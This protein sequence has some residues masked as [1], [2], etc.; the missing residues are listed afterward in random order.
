MKRKKKPTKKFIVFAAILLI[1]VLI[2]MGNKENDE[3]EKTDISN[4]Q[5][6][7]PE[8]PK[9]PEELEKLEEAENPEESIVELEIEEPYEENPGSLAGV[10][11]PDNIIIEKPEVIGVLVNKT[12]TLPASYAPEDLVTLEDLPT[13]L[14]NPEVNQL[15]SPAYQALKELFN[16]AQEE[17]G[18]Y[19]YAR[20]GYRSYSTQE[21]LYSSY[22]ENHG[23]AAAD[24]YS[25]KPGQSE[26]Q[27]G[28]AMDITCQALNYQLDTT[29][30]ETEE[31]KWVAENA[32]RFGFIIRYPKGKE[33]ITGYNYE[34][35]HLRYL[36]TDLATE[37]Y[38]SG[39][40]LE[41][42][43]EQENS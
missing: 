23:Q 43:F 9:E 12:R 37:V 6:Y 16:A 42:F 32:H 19:L 40:T 13:V 5:A 30:A 21:A 18:Y 4:E 38:E 10:E 2:Y 39:L 1:I 34:P 24:K 27:T 17:A 33:H 36:G 41:G 29:F 26:H 15:R 22:V 11:T 8:E 35:W 20:S 7:E 31:G 3:R 28:L 25:A 14:V